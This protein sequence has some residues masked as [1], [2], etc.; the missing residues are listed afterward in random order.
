M[1]VRVLNENFLLIEVGSELRTVFSA[2][3]IFL[4][5]QVRDDEG[6]SMPVTFPMTNKDMSLDFLPLAPE[7]SDH[8]WV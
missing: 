7:W 1:G 4:S 2:I 8:V 3:Y 5:C 6:I